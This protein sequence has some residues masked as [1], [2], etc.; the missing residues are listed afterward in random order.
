MSPAP[1]KTGSLPGARVGAAGTTDADGTG[2]EPAEGWSPEPLPEAF[3]AAGSVGLDPSGE[4]AG[5][6]SDARPPS[7]TST[8]RETTATRATWRAM[9]RLPDLVDI[10]PPLAAVADSVSHAPGQRLW[11][12]VDRGLESQ[13]GIPHPH[14]L[15]LRELRIGGGEV[16]DLC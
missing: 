4:V 14:P 10:G 11:L 13:R 8:A 12:G 9:G 2:D 7:R 16:A 5:S 6:V 15:V 3:A 1:T